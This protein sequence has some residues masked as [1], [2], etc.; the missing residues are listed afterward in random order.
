[1]VDALRRWGSLV[2]NSRVELAEHDVEL[3]AMFRPHLANLRTS[4]AGALARARAQGE[5]RRDVGPESAHLVMA[6]VQA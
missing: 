6:V 3:A 2:T 5:L 4:F 1:M